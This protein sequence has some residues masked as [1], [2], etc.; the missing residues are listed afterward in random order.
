MRW[1][2]VIKP[3]VGLSTCQSAPELDSEPATAPTSSGEREEYV[4]RL[5]SDIKLG[6]TVAAA[7][8]C[9]HMNN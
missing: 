6:A 5:L 3:L 1:P 9:S 7:Y 8:S 2:L 4:A